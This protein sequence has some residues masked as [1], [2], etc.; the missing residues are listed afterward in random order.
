MSKRTGSV[1]EHYCYSSILSSPSLWR[2]STGSTG[3]YR[4]NRVGIKMIIGKSAGSKIN[5]YEIYIYEDE[6]KRNGHV[7]RHRIF[8]LLSPR[9]RKHFNKI[10]TSSRHDHSIIIIIMSHCPKGKI[11]YIHLSCSQK[12]YNDIF[13]NRIYIRI[14][15]IRSTR[16]IQLDCIMV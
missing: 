8:A 7:I 15:Q 3:K 11:L 16:Y 2:L 5:F 4:A 1:G 12:S 10:G 6:E 9:K 14:R 13:L